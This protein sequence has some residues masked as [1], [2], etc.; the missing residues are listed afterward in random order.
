LNSKAYYY[1]GLHDMDVI[2]DK[3]VDPNPDINDLA[4][5]HTLPKGYSFVFYKPY[6]INASGFLDTSVPTFDVKFTYAAAVAGYKTSGI[7]FLGIFK[8]GHELK[9]IYVDASSLSL[10][11]PNDLND[12][13]KLCCINYSIHHGVFGRPSS[14]SLGGFRL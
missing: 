6:V 10:D 9:Y 7:T 8:W 2:I 3:A 1:E 12:R 4:W 11:I 5:N 13:K 14:S